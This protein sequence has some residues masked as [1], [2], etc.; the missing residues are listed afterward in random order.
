MKNELAKLIHEHLE[1]NGVYLTTKDYEERS[2]NDINTY[3][4]DALKSLERKIY[5]FYLNKKEDKK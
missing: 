2:F 5:K 3:E 1:T 4:T